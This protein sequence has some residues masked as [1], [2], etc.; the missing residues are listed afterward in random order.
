MKRSTFVAEQDLKLC[1]GIFFLYGN[2][3]EAEQCRAVSP[4]P[5]KSSRV[6]VLYVTLRSYLI[7]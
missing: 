4:L 5:I 6:R 1:H 3:K 2:P 7:K